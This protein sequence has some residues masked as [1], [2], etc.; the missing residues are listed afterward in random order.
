MEMKIC[1]M[2]LGIVLLMGCANTAVRDRQIST[3]EMDKTEMLGSVQTSFNLTSVAVGPIITNPLESNIK[4]QAYTRLLEEAN[5]I[6]SGNI[7]IRN[8][9]ITEVG[10]KIKWGIGYEYTY[11]AS[12]NVISTYSNSQR[13]ANRLDGITNQI[14]NAF[15]G[16]KNITLAIFDF[17]NV[18]GKQSILG[19]Y[20]VEQTSNFLFQNSDIRIVE[21]NQ[22]DKI[23]KE[24]N[25]NMSGYVGDE[26]AVQI[27]HMVGAN[28]VALGTLTK[29]GNKISV[30]IKIVE[31]E[32][33]A[34][35]SSG[36]TEIE[37]AEY[38]EMYNEMLE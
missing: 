2:A 35:L 23:I 10:R 9:T 31:T 14:T 6:Y 26:S 3:Q 18:N 32:S 11:M 34:L 16:N 13:V 27:G 15:Q 30:N 33:S 20:I 28:A 37:G 36:S 12:G 19:R 22:I 25:F 21:R 7:D 5:K 1:L 38:L 4:N 24:L 17:I 8:I 29:V